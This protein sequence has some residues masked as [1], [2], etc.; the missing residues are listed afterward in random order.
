MLQFALVPATASRTGTP[1]APNV[2]SRWIRPV[3]RANANGFKTPRKTATKPRIHDP[4]PDS[5]A[6]PV[7][8]LVS[9]IPSVAARRSKEPRGEF[10]SE[11]G[12]GG[13]GGLPE[14]RTFGQRATTVAGDEVTG[15]DRDGGTLAEARRCLGQ[16]G[17]SATV[18]RLRSFALEKEVILRSGRVPLEASDFLSPESP[19]E[20]WLTR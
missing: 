14:P 16:D 15:G 3:M 2:N 6:C 10:R 5:R 19:C 20:T 12:R 11:A 13:S 17:S 7:H 18:R 9:A 8:A 4:T 1:A